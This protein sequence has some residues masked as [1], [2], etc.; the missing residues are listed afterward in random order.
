MIGNI[1]KLNYIT[2]LRITTY[3]HKQFSKIIIKH[4]L[5]INNYNQ[6]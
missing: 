1:K 2:D 6:N 4:L 5:T 3:L